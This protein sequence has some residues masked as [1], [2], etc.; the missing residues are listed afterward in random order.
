ME[1]SGENDHRTIPIRTVHIYHGYPNKYSPRYRHDRN[2][3]FYPECLRLRPTQIP[4][5][6]KIE[7]YIFGIFASRD[8]INNASEREP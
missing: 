8:I 6:E 4:I 1:A 5:N 3:Q 7:K 2:V